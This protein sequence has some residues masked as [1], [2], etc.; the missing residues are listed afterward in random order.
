MSQSKAEGTEIRAQEERARREYDAELRGSD[1]S[2]ED[3]S[4]VRRS[5]W[6]TDEP[7]QLQEAA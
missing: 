1:P 5:R 4:T 3:W 7:E 2:G 6:F